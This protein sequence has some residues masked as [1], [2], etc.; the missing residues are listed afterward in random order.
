MIHYDRIRSLK[1]LRGQYQDPGRVRGKK[2]KIA[3]QRSGRWSREGRRSRE[4]RRK[5]GG[6]EI[7]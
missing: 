6:G 5:T 4:E 3:G 1:A 7:Q 2:S